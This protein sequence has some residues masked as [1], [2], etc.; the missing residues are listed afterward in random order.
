MQSH[1]E[2]DM[3]TAQSVAEGK[4]SEEYV[5]DAQLEAVLEDVTE[6][7]FARAAETKRVFDD[8]LAYVRE[9]R[10]APAAGD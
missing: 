3:D 9:V 4:E 8:F 2:Y 6:S 7:N 10:A 5:S 1:P